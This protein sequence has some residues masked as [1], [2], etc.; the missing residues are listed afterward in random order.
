MLERAAPACFHGFYGLNYVFDNVS[1]QQ[2]GLCYLQEV[3]AEGSK[4]E[5]RIGISTEFRSKL[6]VLPLL[7]VALFI[8]SEGCFGHCLVPILCLMQQDG[9]VSTLV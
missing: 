3:W 4:F 9:A 6:Y 7:R 2:C 8:F 1:Y 5:L